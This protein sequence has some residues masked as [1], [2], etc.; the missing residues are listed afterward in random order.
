MTG[1]VQPSDVTAPTAGTA[2]TIAFPGGSPRVAFGVEELAAALHGR[3][4]VARRQDLDRAPRRPSGPAVVVTAPRADLSGEFRAAVRGDEV[5]PVADESF[6]IV[7]HD[8]GV[9]E[10]SGTTPSGLL[11]GLLEVAELVE[12]A[13]WPA[14]GL[15]VRRAAAIALRGFKFNLPYAPYADGEPFERNLETAWS[16]E[17]WGGFLDELARGR[18]NLLSLWSEHPWHLLVTSDRFRGANPASDAEM[19]RRREFFDE[20]LRRAD[21]R[22]IGV[23]LFT[24][25]ISL[26]AEAAEHLGVPPVPDGFVGSS[27]HVR[28]RQASPVVRDYIEEMILRT[29]VTYPLLRG[30]GTSASETMVGSAR[31]R[32]AWVADVFVAAYERS[33]RRPWFIQRTNLQ[34]AGQEIK[35]LVQPR[36]PPERFFVSWKYANA[37]AL[38]HPRPRFEDLRRAWDGVDLEST[39][40]L[41]TVRNDDVTTHQWA[42]AEFV[43]DFVEG[44]RKPYVRGFYWGAD[45]YVFGRDFQHVD[46]GH[47]TWRWDYE[48]HVL[49]FRLWGRLAF[50]PDAAD[51]LPVTVLRRVHGEH[52]EVVAEGLAHASRIVPAVNRLLWR[53]YDYQWHPEICLGR[54]DGFRT[55]LDLLEAEPMPGQDVVSIAEWGRTGVAGATSE[56]PASVSALLRREAGAA[57]SSADDLAAH[58]PHVGAT[59]C[60]ELDLRGLAS[61]G[62]YYA[63]KIDAA[64]ELVRAVDDPQARDRAVE[65]LESAVGH[66]KDVGHHWSRHYRAYDMPR[67]GRTFGYPFYL[68]DVEHDV[69]LARRYG[70]PDLDG[71]MLPE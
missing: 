3:G 16:M 50:D 26:T 52:A 53:D 29:L 65:A 49:Q 18:Y 43:R 33:G 25:N 44:M 46:H 40:V 37:H 42:D 68:D 6:E 24:W 32:Q 58:G 45:G 11:Y 61:L 8:D 60:V 66:W 17:F 48:R 5:P 71:A 64:V 41:F 14:P 67:T 4:L 59:A 47:K 30:I 54:A 27:E 10:V 56:T 19:A 51:H 63:A 22:G 57:R 28:V 35:E 39:N 34:G 38:S 7:S 23:V 55:V 70:R 31:D 62:E 9:V 21:D 36:F 12:R 1:D 20:L 13:G 69:A 15:V 2:V